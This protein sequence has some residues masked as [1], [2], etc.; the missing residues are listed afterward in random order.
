MPAINNP[1]VEAGVQIIDR[2]ERRLGAYNRRI[3]LLWGMARGL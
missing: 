3:K 1:S 2:I